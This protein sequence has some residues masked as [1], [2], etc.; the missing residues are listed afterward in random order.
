MT[1]DQKLRVAILGY[2]HIAQKHIAALKQLNQDFELVAICDTNNAVLENAMQEHGVDGYACLRSMLTEANIDIVTLCTPSG[3]HA[4]QTK[5]IA[6]HGKHVVCE[7]PMATKWQHAVEMVNACNEANVKLFVVKQNRGHPTL[8]LL[9]KAITTGRFGKIFNVN[10]NV[11]WTRPQDYYDKSPWRGTWD[12]D[13]GALMNQAS[14][15]VDLLHW[16]IGPIEDVH[17]FAATQARKME[18]ED[19]AALVLRWRHGALGTMNV[20]M[21][22]YPKNYE[23]SL[24]IIGE[25]GTVKIGGVAVNEIQHWQFADPQPEDQQIQA[26]TEQTQSNVTQGHVWY[27]QNVVDALRGKARA[28]TDGYEGLKSLAVIIAAYRS[29][30]DNK[31]ISLPL[32]L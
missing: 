3:L 18:A 11:F 24:T 10:L 14:H 5:L 30:R 25:K 31:T 29:A 28:E 13:G 9:K 27:Y 2:G 16:L 12:F 20:S 17:A 22:T 1:N 7:K 8:Q 26:I 15:Y 32:E 21:L 19:S 23:A 4:Q 6:S